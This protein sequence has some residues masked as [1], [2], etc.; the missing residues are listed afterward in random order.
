MIYNTFISRLFLSAVV[1]VGMLGCN[2]EKQNIDSDVTVLGNETPK[3]SIKIQ[4]PSLDNVLVTKAVGDNI[5]AEPDEAAINKL[6]VYIFKKTGT[7]GNETDYTFF[8]KYPFDASSLTAGGASAKL[9]SVDIEPEIMN[10]TVRA[11]LVANDEPTNVALSA[12]I[13]T[14]PSFRNALA[15]ATVA[16]G[17]TADDLV[18][19]TNKSFPMSCVTGDINTTP[20]GNNVDATLVRSMARIDILNFAKD[21]YITSVKLTNVNNKSCLLGKADAGE[22]NIPTAGTMPKIELKPLTEYSAKITGVDFGYDA[23]HDAEGTEAIRKAN[24][25]RVFYLY[26]QE[27]KDKASSPV[28]E[29][30]YTA[31]NAKVTKKGKLTVKFCKTTAPN[32]WVNVKRNHIYTIQLGEEGKSV[33]QGEM[34]VRFVVDDWNVVTVPSEIIPYSL[35][36][37]DYML[38]DGT[39]VKPDALQPEQQKDVIGIV[40]YL[41]KTENNAHLHDGVKEALKA[42]GVTA[43]HGLV[44]ALKNTY[45]NV[46]KW[47]IDND[48]RRK[49]IVGNKDEWITQNY[50]NG[51]DGYTV[52]TKVYNDR[53]LDE[54]P[55]FKETKEYGTKVNAPEN[56]TG[57]YLPSIGEWLDM[58]G[59]KGLKVIPADMFAKGVKQGEPNKDAIFGDIA[60]QVATNLNAKFNKVGASNFDAFAIKQSYWSATEYEVSLIYYVCFGS[61]F[62]S[63]NNNKMLIMDGSDN[64]LVRP[65]LAF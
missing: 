46:H 56:T 17:N 34:K 43:P 9:C 38:K 15:T 6:N 41:Y 23:T 24:K 27:V 57:W 61:P 63:E 53:K 18:G 54:Y 33:L 59:D 51:P 42:K 5:A 21:L 60:D 45:N 10:Q 39:T 19:G 44:M 13:T 4:S 55:V 29:I 1:A 64:P 49:R 30:E 31:K 11:A 8:K 65:I 14:L 16:T 40:A 37:G 32:D 35:A 22:L 58:L 62:S 36:V 26:E 3:I 25:H 20:R 52:T 12:G 2:G 28:V 48:Y 50:E 47:T 7:A